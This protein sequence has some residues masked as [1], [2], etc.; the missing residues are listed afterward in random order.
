MAI[1]IG[2]RATPT[3]VRFA[4]FDG[5]QRSVVNIEILRIPTAFSGPEG[6]KFIR[7]NVLD[8]LREYDVDYAGIRTTEPSAKSIDLRRVQVEGVI[9]EAFASS[10]LTSFYAGPIAII[11]H[12]LGVDRTRFKPM[13]AGENDFDIEGWEGMPG[14]SREAV[15]AAIGAANV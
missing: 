6:L 5:D 7:S 8:I 15:L 1:T 11:A 4:V 14:N 12:R 13:V 3:D 10:T 2:F 9:Q